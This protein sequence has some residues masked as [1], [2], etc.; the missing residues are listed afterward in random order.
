MSEPAPDNVRV[1]DR[2]TVRRHRDRAAAASIGGREGGGGD[3]LHREIAGRLVE[4]L[5]EVRRD[6]ANVLELGCHRG[7]LTGLL[8]GR[9]GVE[10]LI[11][12]DLSPV[13]VA[14][15][16]GRR[17]GA[18]GVVADEEAL[19]FEPGAFDLVISN[20]ALHWVNDVPGAL[21]QM[22]RALKPDGLLLAAF[23]GGATLAELREALMAAELE[24][25]GGASPR[26]SP[27]AD[28]RDAGALLQRA[29]FAL[30]VV[31]RD[32]ISVSYD[33]ALDLMA[34]LRAMAETNAVAERSTRFTRRQT[35]LRAAA[36]YQER[37][38]AADGRIAAGFEV[39]YLTAWAP[40]AAQPR[41]LAPGSATGSLA[42]ALGTQEIA[43]GDP[44]RPG[45][46]DR[47]DKRQT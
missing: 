40:D 4:R 29:G 9:S 23:L 47:G 46:A 27:F 10:T 19:P 25:E 7:A 31:D 20:L 6:F 11:A 8:A 21:I 16:T 35:L 43:A 15:S 22:R 18:F 1:F 28:V 44:T 24:I 14:L 32:R 38:G 45:P 42:D 2:R 5:D 3:F 36:L 12:A 41:P 17:K 13:C 39:I 34:D 30:P 37:F 33:S 26:V